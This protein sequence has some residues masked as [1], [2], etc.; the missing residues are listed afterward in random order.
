MGTRGGAARQVPGNPLAGLLR[1]Q[2]RSSR[3]VTG[4]LSGGAAQTY[5]AIVTT[6][7]SGQVVVSFPVSFLQPPVVQAT[8]VTDQPRFA[9]V[10]EATTTNATL[11]VWTM[12]GAPASGVTVHVTANERT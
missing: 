11:V 8:V 3:T 7:G 12:A 9:T 2:Q 4:P 5:S 1:D 10:L 6:G